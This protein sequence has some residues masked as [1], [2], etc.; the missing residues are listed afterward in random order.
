MNEQ[1]ISFKTDRLAK[2]K[3]FNEPCYFYYYDNECLN[4][5]FIENGSSTDVEFRVDVE[6]FLEKHN[7]EYYDKFSAPTQSLLQ[8]W[9]REVKLIDISVGYNYCKEIKN[10]HGFLPESFYQCCITDIRNNDI[11][12]DTVGYGSKTYE[13]ALEMGLQEA[14]EL[15]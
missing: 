11:I 7:F 2:E 14:L 4:T 12:S 6:D 9:F 3:G 5:P 13:D 8:K 10:K 15:I 1:L